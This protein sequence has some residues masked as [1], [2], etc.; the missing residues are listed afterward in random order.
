MGDKLKL[1]NLIILE[2]FNGVFQAYFE[3]V[4]EIFKRDFVDSKPVFNKK[5]LRL[6]THPL[7]DGKEYTFYHFTHSGDI[8]NERLPDFRRMERIGWA[9]PVI[10]EYNNWGLKIWPQIR[11]GKDRLCIWLEF[12][13]DLDY[14]V[15]LDVR[16]NYILPW[17]AFVL[18]YEHE[19]RK[20]Q[21]EYEAYLKTRTA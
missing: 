6:K 1:P 14:I 9:K 20:K 12:E 2:S 18:E 3:A 7:I 4:Y 11:N 5:Q 21:K 8:E 16:T 13:N 15:I 17:T 10:E 19:K